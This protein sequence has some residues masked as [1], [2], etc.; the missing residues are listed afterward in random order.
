[1]SESARFETPENVQVSYALAGLGSRFIAWFVDQIFVSIAM[2]VILIV[3]ALVGVTFEDLFGQFRENLDFDPEHAESA[4]AVMFGVFAIIAGLGS[5]AYFTL[6]E[7][8]WRGQTPG[9]RMIGIRVVKADGFA[10]DP[11]SIFVRNIV[12]VLDNFPLMWVIPLLSKRSQRAGDMV[13]GTIV[14]GEE[15]LDLGSVRTELSERKAVDSEFR[16]DNRSL[17]KLTESDFEGVERLLE[18]W[19]S[20]LEEQKR[21]MLDRFVPPLAAKMGLEAPPEDRRLRFLEDLLAAELRN[22]N[23]LLG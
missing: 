20:L 17:A 21:T 2:V 9:K 14:I 15:T 22:R 19:S 8:L 12:R 18:R 13:A 3:V 23:R 16:F 7:L 10:L 5:F 6:C 4:V 11:S 1:M